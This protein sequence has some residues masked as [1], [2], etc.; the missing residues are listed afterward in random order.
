MKIAVII[1]N[2]NG[3]EIIKKNLPRVIESIK[4]YDSE[5]IIVDDCSQFFDY[6]S[7]KKNIEA[8]EGNIKITL[9]RNDTNLG[10]SSSVNKGVTS[11]N[12]EYVVLLNSDV[13]PEKDFLVSPIKI[14]DENQNLFGVGCMDR[15]IENGKTILRG[16]GLASWSRGFLIHRRGEVDSNNT[17]WI[18]GGSSI[19]RRELFV[20]L[21]GFDSIYNPF[22]WE[23]IDLSFRARKAGYD[24]LFDNKSIVEHRHLEGAIKKHYSEK[25]I[26]TIAYRNQIVFVWK[27][28]T[29]YKL[30]L[31]NII[32]LP[33]HVVITIL[34]KDVNF[35]KGFC[36]ALGL[37]P[38]IIRK[39][40]KLKKVFTKKDFE[41]I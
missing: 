32:W 37:L 39:R 13:S 18:S 38:A 15:S 19:I 40:K 11:T 12:A 3:S 34:R 28:I 10:F 7:L 14:L 41:V 33:Y 1:P 4:N 27:N 16:R 5:I 31:L 8:V 2:Y 36:L 17:F 26:N 30:L 23:D 35:I 21:G 25:Q 6:E 24:I 9:L 20:K 22:Y 29:S